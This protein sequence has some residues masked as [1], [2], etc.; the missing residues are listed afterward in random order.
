MPWSTFPSARPFRVSAASAFCSSS[1]SARRLSTTLRSRTSVTRNRSRS[2]MNWS[3]LSTKRRSIWLSGTNARASPTAT[4]KPPLLTARTSPSTGIPLAR[5]SAS[6]ASD[7]E[8]LLSVRLRMTPL[9]P[10]STTCASTVSPTPKRRMPSSS[11]S[12]R[13]SIIASV[14]PPSVRN[15]VSAPSWKMVP[16]TRSPTR[17]IFRCAP[18]SVFAWASNISAKDWSSRTSS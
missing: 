16:V 14:R 7:A 18:P 17:G 10:A 11:F 6:I 3:G 1:S 5:A 8:P 2:P 13:R 9:A 4:S 15:A 12:S